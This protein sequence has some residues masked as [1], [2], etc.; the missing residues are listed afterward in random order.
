MMGSWLFRYGELYIPEAEMA[1]LYLYR[2]DI[3][4]ENKTQGMYLFYLIIGW[5]ILCVRVVWLYASDF[6]LSKIYIYIYNVLVWVTDHH[7]S[8]QGLLFDC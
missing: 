8:T 2:S 3:G 1:E 4:A 7:V 5:S 6:C